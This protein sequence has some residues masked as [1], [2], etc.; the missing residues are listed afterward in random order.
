VVAEADRLPA[1][2][3]EVHLGQ[4]RDGVDVRRRG[5]EHDAQ[6]TSVDEPATKARDQRACG[7]RRGAEQAASLDR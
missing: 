1:R 3:H 5:V 4:H 2:E 6:L 7:D